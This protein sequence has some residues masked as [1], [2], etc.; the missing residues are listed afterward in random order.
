MN[1]ILEKSQFV[2]FYTYLDPIFEAVP[3]L[4]DFQYLISD[5]Q[6]TACSHFSF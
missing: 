6:V 5:P 3:Q 4:A 1:L 2:D